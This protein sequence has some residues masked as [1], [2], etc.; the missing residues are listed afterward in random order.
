MK[1]YSSNFSLNELLAVT[2]AKEIKDY[3]V[4]ISGIGIPTMAST[5]AKVTHAK[6]IV[7]NTEWGVVD[8]MPRRLM[9]GVSCSAVNERVIAFQPQHF[10]MND[11]QRGCYDLGIIGGA[12]VDKFGNVNSTWISQPGRRDQI[13]IMLAGSGGANDIATSA[14]RVMIMMRSTKKNF[15]EHVDYITSPG[16]LGGPGER[17]L[18]GMPGG[19]PFIVISAEGTFRFDPDTKEMYLDT[20]HPG[21]TVEDIKSMVPWD[22]KVSPD[23]RET[24]KPTDEAI[25]IL[26]TIDPS[27]VYL[28]EGKRILGEGHQG[29]FEEFLRIMNESFDP[30]DKLINN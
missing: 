2:A 24:E 18:Y 27:G 6:N 1:R 15:V 13:K 22:L 21:V 26:R 10:I 12:Q 29:N 19:G 17:E 3:E 20:Y 23:V 8:P 4:L 25:A 16:Y 9:F 30:M 11:M 5:L 7:V 28:G 14:N